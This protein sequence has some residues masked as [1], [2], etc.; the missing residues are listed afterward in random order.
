M[1]LI[2]TRSGDRGCCTVATLQRV[3]IYCTKAHSE[4]GFQCSKS[5]GS[6]IHGLNH[7]K[8]TD[9]FQVKVPDLNKRQTAGLF[10]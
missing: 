1:H 3:Y 8:V 5:N 4:L 10:I 6:V 9:L 7:S 2:F